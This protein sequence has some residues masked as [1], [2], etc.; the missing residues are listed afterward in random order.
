MFSF[1]LSSWQWV[2]VG[3]NKHSKFISLL[4]VTGQLRVPTEAFRAALA[5]VAPRPTSH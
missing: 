1:L 5:M 2:T 3:R 4:L